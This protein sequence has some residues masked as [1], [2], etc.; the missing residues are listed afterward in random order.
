MSAASYVTR[1]YCKNPGMSLPI[2]TAPHVCKLP[3][4]ISEDSTHGT[5][6]GEKGA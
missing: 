1:R 3:L 6:L 2:Y 5:H 4:H